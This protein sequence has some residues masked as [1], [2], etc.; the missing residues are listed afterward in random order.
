MTT[1][2]IAREASPSE[3]SLYKAPG[4]KSKYYCAIHKPRVIYTARINQSFLSRDGVLSLEFDGGVGTLADVKADMMMYVGSSAGARDVAIVRIRYTDATHFYVEQTSEINYQDN[5]YLTV[6][7]DFRLLQRNVS[8]VSGVTYMDASIEYSNQHSNPDPVP[9]M[10]SHRV[11]KMTEATV[12]VEFDFSDSYVIDGSTIASKLTTAPTAVSVDDATT[13][14]PTV[15]YDTCGWHAVYLTLTGTNGSTFFGVRYVY[16]WN[17]DNPPPKVKVGS[18]PGDVNSGGWS[19]ELELYNNA[20]I[21]DIYEGS[22]CIL[23]SED[24]YGD[25]QQAIGSVH[26][27]ENIEAVGWITS[28]ELISWNPTRSAVK[29]SVQGPHHWMSRIS[30]YPAGVAFTSSEPEEW[31]EFKN[32]TVDKGAWH[33]LHWRC[34]ATRILD[35]FPSGVTRLAP[36][37]TSLAT[38]LFSQLQEMA[39]LGI[40]A[41]PGFN[42]QGQFFLQVHPQLTPES[43]R[44]WNTV[45][46]IT[47]HDWRDEVGLE[48]ITVPEVTQIFL[49]GIHISS[50]GDGASYFALAPGH[51][52]SRYG[53]PESVERVL[54]IS[55]AQAITLAGLYYGWRN[56]SLPDIP[57]PLSANIRLIDLFPN[58]YCSTS[59]ADTDTARGIEYSGRIIPKSITVNFDDNTGRATREVIFEAETFEGLAV[60][61]IIQGSGD[62]TYMPDFPTFP[63]LPPFDSILPGTDVLPPEG[64]HYVLAHDNV[65]AGLVYTSN[66]HETEPVWVQLNGGLTSDQYLAIQQIEFCPSGA[67][68]VA[69]LGNSNVREI[70]IARAP[71]LGAT[72]TIIED[73]TTLAVKYPAATIFCLRGLGIDKTKPE[74]VAY[75]AGDAATES[76]DIFYGLTGVFTQEVHIGNCTRE[77]SL[78]YG[79][80]KWL[81]T[82]EGWSFGSVGIYS[83]LS[84]DCSSILSAAVHFWYTAIRHQRLGYSGKTYHFVTN[85]ADILVGT[86][87]LT[88][89]VRVGSFLEPLGYHGIAFDPSGTLMMSRY[90]AG[91][92]GKSSDGGSSWSDITGLAYTGAWAFAYAGGSG[93]TSRWVAG[94]S[95]MQYSDNF[96]VTWITKQGNLNDISPLYFL[97]IVKAIGYG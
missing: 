48:R 36:E 46:N 23:F 12:D 75:A 27:S 42:A 80:G 44:T 55:Q 24:Y 73:E 43:E 25:T 95:Y 66:F 34:T 14:Y 68:Y 22:L 16:I 6:V 65:F 70:F 15:T 1:F 32:L 84:A 85:E 51:I 40:F 38:D 7:E 58:Q 83:L 50:S 39:A 78:T 74:A 62:L 76:A 53:K 13:F 29:L 45:M 92:K 19:F 94:S 77:G 18:I 81:F 41:R 61:E 87:N 71:S 97:D 30:S 67:V 82:Y 21:D 79:L 96:G 72:F 60:Q 5:Q 26:G 89:E 59:I 2:G 52:Y 8:I 88:S 57:I 17:E 90:A 33:F 64:P 37:V 28:P 91:R 63:E 56:N 93:T 35:F 86:D 54:V 69:S 9:V 20:T 49:S 10:G 31:T 4:K 47:P 3:L 11:L